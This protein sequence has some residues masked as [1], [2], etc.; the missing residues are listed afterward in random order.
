MDNKKNFYKKLADLYESLQK[1]EIKPYV[2]TKNTGGTELSYLSWGAAVDFFT[3]SCNQ[4]G[5][6]WNYTQETIAD[7]VLGYEVHTTITIYDS[8]SD[9]TASK[10]MS[11]PAMDGANKAVKA[12]AWEYSTKSAKRTVEPAD[13]FIINKTKQRCLVKTMTLFGLGLSLYLKD[14]MD[15]GEVQ[16]GLDVAEKASKEI[17]D[18]KK[19]IAKLLEKLPT[20]KRKE[21]DGY[22]DLDDRKQLIEIGIK[23]KK[24]VENE[25]GK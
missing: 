15:L 20:D 12:K 17:A 25:A 11:L 21:F 9:L 6:F 2:S 22:T 18:L 23:A 7:E 5:L 10:A 13:S 16:T 8:E 3:K 1:S 14:N 4:L 19:R 24:A